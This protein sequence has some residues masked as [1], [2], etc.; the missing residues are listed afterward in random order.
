MVHDIYYYM[1]LELV[2]GNSLHANNLSKKEILKIN[3]QNHQKGLKFP[4]FFTGIT[5]TTEPTGI[6]IHD[7][8]ITWKFQFMNNARI[9]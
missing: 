8:R 9:W 5:T 1:I 6:V 4:A 7:T 2:V 3:F